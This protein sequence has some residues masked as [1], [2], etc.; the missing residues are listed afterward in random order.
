[1]QGAQSRETAGTWF[2]I[3]IALLA[4]AWLM[5][6]ACG[7]DGA[8]TPDDGGDSEATD[9]ADGGD[10][11]DGPDGETT[12]C[13]DTDRDGYGRGCAAGPDC[14]DTDPAVYNM[15]S[16]CGGDYPPAGCVC[17]TTGNP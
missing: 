9:E 7:D 12:S 17:P 3:G 6:A 10:T 4:F 16:T 13:V 14:D 11:P 2:R 8:S 1:M 5:P 15:C